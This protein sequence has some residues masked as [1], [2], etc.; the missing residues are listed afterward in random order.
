MSCRRLLAC[1]DQGVLQA[2][3]ILLLNAVKGS[4]ERAYVIL[5]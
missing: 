2:V 1:Q 5:A 3:V 4:K